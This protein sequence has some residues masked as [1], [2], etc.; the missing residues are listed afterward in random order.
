M[1]PLGDYLTT[2]LMNQTP[3][4]IGLD[5]SKDTLHINQPVLTNTTTPHHYHQL[6]NELVNIETWA[7]SLPP[8]T[9]VIFEH[10]GTYSARRA[11]VLALQGIAFTALQATQ[12]AG[13]AKSISKS[14]RRDAVLLTHY[15]QQL[16][17]AP[18]PLTEESLHQLRQCQRHLHVLRVQYQATTNR[19]HALA[20]DPRTA[21]RV[22]ASRQRLADLLQ[23]EILAF[24]TGQ[25]LLSGAQPAVIQA[26]MERVVGIGPAWAQALCVATNGLQGF[27]SA[28]AV[29]KYVGIAP[30][31]AQ[32][33]T[34]VRS[35]G[36]LVGTSVG[37]VR[38]V[39]YMAARSARR[40]N[41]SCRS[42]YERLRARGKCHRV[43]II[44]VIN[45][46]L[47][48]VFAVVKTNTGFVNGQG[49]TQ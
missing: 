44:A 13:F 45:K 9:Q 49:M 28:K 3:Y 35:R 12:S 23:A 2:T 19:L 27:E 34:S 46:L 6:D 14:D 32:S 30:R 22:V 33:G 39:L 41:L 21:Q 20:H 16:Q 15:G 36:K 11:W 26:R 25:D 4:Y 10:T 43:A 18:T 31:Q 29:V 48:Q 47:H 37:Y 8:N 40:Y 7:K 5:V 17:P 42:L 24:E 38:G 1:S